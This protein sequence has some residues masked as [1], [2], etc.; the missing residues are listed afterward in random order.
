MQGE[1]IG[2]MGRARQRKDEIPGSSHTMRSIYAL[3]IFGKRTRFKSRGDC[4]ERGGLPIEGKAV[5]GEAAIDTT[6]RLLCLPSTPPQSK[7]AKARD[8]D[9]REK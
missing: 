1:Q 4:R 6:V 7:G 5:P 9:S 8:C 3:R 2:V